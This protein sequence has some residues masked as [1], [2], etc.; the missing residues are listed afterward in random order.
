MNYIN[1]IIEPNKL[2]I[3]WQSSDKA[4]RTR[5][6]VAELRKAHEKITLEYLNNTS[7]FRQACALGFDA[8][9]AF[10]E[11]DKIHEQGI[12]DALMRRLPPKTRG[13]YV[14]YLEGFRINPDTGMSDFALL[15]YTGARLPS[16]GFAI[17]HPFNNANTPFE[18]LAE[19]AGYRYYRNHVQINANEPVS[20]IIEPDA[21][22]GD[23]I[24]IVSN[25]NLIG[26]ITRALIPNFKTWLKNEW[27]KEAWI[28]KI[29]G[30]PD[31]PIIYIYVR[32][33]PS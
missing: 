26:Y 15:G 24:K 14:Q 32:V 27:V 5:F 7:D 25:N 33:E 23:T 20:F 4:H 16:D 1:H 30:S 9:P 3:T 28:E 2:L 31:H 6:V 21:A 11:T 13:D 10:R 29:N 8:Y 12:M 22:F 18:F 19:A 17:I